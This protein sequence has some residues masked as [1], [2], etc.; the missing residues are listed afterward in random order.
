MTKI[1]LHP[2]LHGNKACNVKLWLRSVA[3]YLCKGTTQESVLGL[4]RL[5]FILHV[6]YIPNHKRCSAGTFIHHVNIASNFVRFIH[7][8]LNIQLYTQKLV[9]SLEILWPSLYISSILI[10][11]SYLKTVCFEEYFWLIDSW[12][13]NVLSSVQT[14][15]Q[16]KAS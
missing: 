8:F 7:P 15:K 14:I 2:M 11:I 1:F 10:W 12:N 6:I 3:L 5:I 16:F 4:A 13:C 9:P